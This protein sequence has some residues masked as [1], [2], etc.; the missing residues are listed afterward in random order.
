[1]ISAIS[2]K[3]EPIKL[4]SKTIGKWTLIMRNSELVYFDQDVLIEQPHMLVSLRY[5]HTLK[6]ACCTCCNVCTC[7]IVNSLLC[8]ILVLL[9]KNCKNTA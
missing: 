2:L 4:I 8:V 6:S 1:M 7:I 5:M 3:N 9:Q